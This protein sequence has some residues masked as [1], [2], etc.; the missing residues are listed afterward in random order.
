M[1]GR[2]KAA[3]ATSVAGLGFETAA[4][5]VVPTMAA[6]GEFMVG[7]AVCVALA[8][9]WGAIGAGVVG[10]SALAYSQKTDRESAHRKLQP[11]VWSLI[12]PK[13]PVQVPQ[14]KKKEIFNAALSLLSDGHSQIHSLGSKYQTAAHPFG[15]FFQNVSDAQTQNFK[16]CRQI[17][18]LARDYKW[19][20]Q[21][22]PS[23]PSAQ[24]DRKKNNLLVQIGTLV[25][26]MEAENRHVAKEWNDG[27]ASGGFV[28]NYMRRIVHIG[29]Y[30]QS[31][32]VV[33]HMMG[34]ALAPTSPAPFLS[35]DP[36][37]NYPIVQYTRD[38]LDQI[39]TSLICIQMYARLVEVYSRGL[40]QHIRASAAFI[41]AQ[42]VAVISEAPIGL[43]KRVKRAQFRNCWIV[44]QQTD[45]RGV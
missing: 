29:N 19:H 39:S 41:P 30:L 3:G 7:G 17:Y 8:G 33:S 36:L 6:M 20:I 26:E 9:P 15:R 35:D 5:I 21:R 1:F 43:L 4:T 12:D 18:F 16:K 34:K 11:Y 45:P 32:H 31:G 28:F 10:L 38:V 40:P 13:P 2:S 37:V 23:R 44:D 14:D 27:R 22:Q 25:R 42:H 24:F